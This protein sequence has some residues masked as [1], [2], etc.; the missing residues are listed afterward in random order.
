MSGARY[1]SQGCRMFGMPVWL[2]GSFQCR[3]TWIFLCGQKKKRTKISP[4]ERKCAC[5]TLACYFAVTGRLSNCDARAAPA[6][7]FAVTISPPWFAN[8]QALLALPDS[9]LGH[10]NGAGLAPSPTSPRLWS[11]LWCDNMPCSVS[12][13]CA[14]GGAADRGIR[15][16][17][18]RG[19]VGQRYEVGPMCGGV[20]VGWESFGPF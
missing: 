7:G 9:T 13:A 17:S 18:E 3:S 5:Y 15:P 1:P 14:A 8:R 19:K 11:G 16:W 20:V 10:Y 4:A 6:T 2:V 12:A